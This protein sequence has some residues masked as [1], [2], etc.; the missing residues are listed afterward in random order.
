MKY[1]SIIYYIYGKLKKGIYLNELMLLV[2]RND[3]T[4]ITQQLR[5]RSVLNEL[6]ISGPIV[7]PGYMETSKLVLIP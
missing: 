4:S 6:N 1:Y 2:N 7:R 3:K 5:T